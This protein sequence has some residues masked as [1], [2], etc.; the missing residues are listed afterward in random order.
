MVSRHEIRTSAQRLEGTDGFVHDLIC[1]RSWPGRGSCPC[2]HSLG[3]QAEGWP[4]VM[5]TQQ[6]DILQI[7]CRYCV[8]TVQ[9]SCRYCV[10]IV[11]ILCRYYRLYR[12][13]LWTYRIGS[14][15]VGHNLQKCDKLLIITF[16]LILALTFTRGMSVSHVQCS[17]ILVR[18]CGYRPRVRRLIL[19][20]LAQWHTP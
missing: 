16:L 20:W 18:Q 9:I 1:R 7:S 6:V 11:Q 13:D 10:D 17:S 4:G 14:N 5:T 15:I 12:I 8:D 2:R 3:G 19:H